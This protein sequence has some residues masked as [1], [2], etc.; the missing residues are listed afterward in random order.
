MVSMERRSVSIGAGRFLVWVVAAVAAFAITNLPLW[1]QSDAGQISG[2][3]KDASGAVI[4]GAEVVIA[5]EATGLK[6]EI[7]TNDSGYFVVPNLPPGYY[8]LSVEIPGFKKFVKSRNKLDANVAITIEATMEVGEVTEVVQVEASVS[9]VQSETAT[10]GRVVEERQIQNM[11]LNGRNPVLLALLKAGV[12]RGASIASFNYTM[13]SGDF[14][15]NGSRTQDNLITH[16]GAVATRTRANGT[17]IGAI[18]VDAVQEIQI[19]T[20]YN[21]EYGRGNGGQIRIVT[22][23][24]TRDFHASFYE[25]FR[26]TELDANTW[27]L[28]R[29]GLQRPAFKYNQFG[30]NVNGPVFIPGKWNEDRSKLFF[31]WTQEWV[32]FR[33]ESTTTRTVPSL[34]MRQGDFSELLDPSNGF[35]RR[36]RTITDPQTGKPFPNNIILANRVSQNGLAL[37]RAYPE[38]TP[39]F[40]QGTDNFIQVRPNPS[41]Q[42]KDTV[43]LDYYPTINHAFRF[44]FHNFNWTSVD[45]FR[46]GFDRAITDWNR[47]NRTSTVNYTWTINP[48]TINELLVTASVDRVFIGIF[49]PGE[50]FARSKYGIN[51]PYIFPERKEIPDKIPTITIGSFHEL[52]GGPYPAFSS[53]PI[54]QVADNVSRIFGNHTLKLGAWFERSGQN[55][56]DQIN[57][58]GVPGGT[59]NQNGRFTFTDGRAGGTGVAIANVALGLFDTYAEIGPRAFTP[60][61]GHAFAWFIQDSWKVKEKL[62]L[63]IGLRHTMVTP[64]FY[65]LWGNIAVFDPSRYDPK[66]AVVQD[67][68]TGA[69]LSGDVYNG[70]IIPGKGFPEAAKGRVAI[71]DSGEFNRLFNGEDKTWGKYQRSNFEPR[72]GIA[73][74]I[75][76]RTVIRAG[77]GRFMARPGVSDNIFLGGNP[78]FQPMVS[79]A[80]GNVDNPS[81][82]SRT[83]FPL[84]F[85]T[86]DPVFKIPSAYAWN[87]TVQR[88]MG[89]DT[90]VEFGYVGRVGNHLERVRELNALAPGTLQDPKN[91]NINTN[92]LRPFKGFSFINLGE[93]AARSEY[94]GLQAEVNRRFSK[95]LS[96]GF[97][98]TYSNSEDNASGRRDQCWNPFDDRLCWG[99]SGFDTRHIAVFNFIYELPFM[100]ENKLLGGWQITGVMQFQTGTPFTVGRGQDFAGIGSGNAFQ[101]FDVN[102]DHKLSRGERG[103][104]QSN[105]DQNFWFRTTNPDGSAIFTATKA[106]TFAATG[107]R[108]TGYN[109]GFQSWNAAIFKDFGISEDHRFQIRAEFFNFPNHPN[110]GGVSTDPTSATFGRVTGKND[111]RRQIQLALRYSF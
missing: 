105:A 38:P 14:N 54:Y 46:G 50:R 77:G 21:A 95:G 47:P 41:D 27:R 33:Q 8:T 83:G 7:I 93:N 20:N 78:P 81:G 66:K 86:S 56:F 11:M 98:Y 1:A 10:L 19:L 35:F 90:T 101:P 25:Y 57:V 29:A 42:R 58:T 4:P 39:G 100:R 110:W 74:Q 43:A 2:F 23:S 53:G 67:P 15:I 109:P 61:R 106:G 89:F 59:N 32:R 69:I 12:R 49:R 55:D 70:I 5:N 3:V 62:R 31:M 37:L 71:A 28:N 45:A 40:L 80:N 103:F 18:D 9:Q 72:I 44:R 24:G 91:K 85:M 63:E 22:K 79:I 13:T 92:F 111:D 94:H 76:P 36:V 60:Y 51:Y 6:R 64:Y 68:K 73:F 34:K 26:N 96:Y 82:G 48:R 88:E 30:Y 16:D 52:D 87:I 17:A 102:G 99:A 108:S 107:R 104:S 75:T 84:F 97:A 65:S